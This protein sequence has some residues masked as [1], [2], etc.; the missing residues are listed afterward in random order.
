MTV[1]RELYLL[2]VSNPFASIKRQD[3]NT[4]VFSQERQNCFE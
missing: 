4:V 2:C 3:R 1:H